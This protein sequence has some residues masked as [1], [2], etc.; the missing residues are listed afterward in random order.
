MN[1]LGKYIFCSFVLAFL[2][3]PQHVFAQ[4]FTASG[5]SGQIQKA[6]TL[7][8]DNGRRA[9]DALKSGELDDARDYLDDAD[10]QDPYAV[11]VRAALTQ[12]ATT[13]AGMY[14][15][16]VAENEG[17]PIAREALLQL[18]RFHFAAG[19]Y[20]SAHRDY[21][22]LKKFALPPQVSDPL[23]FK[24]SLQ[25]LPASPLPQPSDVSPAADKP[26]T[27]PT[28]YRVQLGVFTTPENARNFVQSLKMYG[29]TGALFTKDDA[30]RTL[31]GVSAGT[32]SSRDAAEDMAA[33]LKKRSI[34]CIVV[35]K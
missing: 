14:K 17:E 23:G 15:E 34:D 16:I 9:Y 13:A 7:G 18:Y 35:E 5:P 4:R 12:D 10:P 26:V 28:L 33:S 30:G 20:N 21:I 8:N 32:F 6:D 24:D 27:Q 11:F 1:R 22:E 19:D 25:A 31:Y 2:V 3:A 29:V